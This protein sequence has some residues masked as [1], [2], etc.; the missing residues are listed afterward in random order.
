MRQ[1]QAT[2]R[3]SSP[4]Q[5]VLSGGG[6]QPVKGR[7][8]QERSATYLSQQG[9]RPRPAAITQ[10]SVEH[11]SPHRSGQVVT[12]AVVASEGSDLEKLLLCLHSFAD[13]SDIA[14]LK[15]GAITWKSETLTAMTN[16]SCPVRLSQRCG[17]RLASGND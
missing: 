15:P 14:Q 5:K 8:V 10:S 4:C 9:D 2:Q 12:L 13:D 7:H 11:L 16:G 17:E 3:A 6:S 1:V